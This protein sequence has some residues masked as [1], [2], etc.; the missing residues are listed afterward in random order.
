[1]GSAENVMQLLQEAMS[2][3]RTGSTK[4]NE[5]SSRSH[6][7]FRIVIESREMSEDGE[8][9][10]PRVEE[11]F[12]G[13]VRVAQLNLVDLAGSERAAHT[14][15]AGQRLKE[16]AHINKSLLTLGSVI[17]KLSEGVTA[18]NGHIPYRDSKL[19]R[20]LQTSLGGNAQTAMICTVT[21][22]SVHSDE[23]LSTL[24]FASRAKKIQN[25]AVVNEIYTDAALLKKLQK[26]INVLKQRNQELEA[27]VGVT[28]LESEKA[29]LEAELRRQKGEVGQK[30]QQLD[31][32]TTLI[33]KA[34]VAS[35][36]AAARGQTATDRRLTWAPGALKS[37]RKN[38]MSLAVGA[39][40]LFADITTDRDVARRGSLGFAGEARQGTL[41]RPAASPLLMRQ[42][43]RLAKGESGLAIPA[44]GLM[45]DAQ[46]ASLE[47]TVSEQQQQLEELQF[48]LEASNKNLEQSLEADIQLAEEKEHSAQLSAEVER[49]KEA[50]QQAE[51]QS[52]QLTARTEEVA[53][54]R[55]DATFMNEELAVYVLAALSLLH[56]F[57]KGTPFAYCAGSPCWLCMAF[58]HFNLPSCLALALSSLNG[59]TR[60]LHSAV[61]EAEGTSSP[62]DVE[63]ATGPLLDEI[64]ALKAKAAET[65][66][67]HKDLVSYLE[68]TVLKLQSKGR[69]GEL[70]KEKADL[71]QHLAEANDT[72]AAV[73]AEVNRLRE[74]ESA[75]A[76]E[77]SRLAA[78]VA[79]ARQEL[80]A[81]QEAL[82]VAKTAAEGACSEHQRLEE[83]ISS[84]LEGLIKADDALQA[85]NCK[86]QDQTD[87]AQSLQVQLEERDSTLATLKAELAAATEAT[88]AA[89]GVHMSVL[90]AETMQARVAE[91][92]K[93]LEM[94]GASHEGVVSS[95]RQTVMDLT[96]REAELS[97]Q[98]DTLKEELATKPHEEATDPST[99]SENA[100]S[101]EFA[102]PATPSRK[103]RGRIA[104]MVAKSPLAK[105]FRKKARRKL[106]QKS[107]ISSPFTEQ[108]ET[109]VSRVDKLVTPSKRQPDFSPEGE[110]HEACAERIAQ[111]Q[112]EYAELKQTLASVEQERN[113]SKESIKSTRLELQEGRLNLSSVESTL[114]ATSAAK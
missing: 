71:E 32:L 67:Q 81:E 20:I 6:S 26:E 87:R 34:G 54:L 1:M 76:A 73:T 79:A 85:A 2:N 100:T 49:L 24:K 68:E 18:A 31:R 97:A 51:L 46:I 17:S 47:K 59:T 61:A 86:A 92:E 83:E 39:D 105:P 91:L 110:G 99:S 23:T 48:M 8:E 82:A 78:E 111:L 28:Q 30:D 10:E 27:G 38:R 98:L 21:P 42:A 50:A 72:L 36:A 62:K 96:Q 35:P 109:C 13:A 52:V 107:D 29:T 65:E 12:D 43:S 74:S 5:E 56:E 101:E 3:R 9:R 106:G 11:E 80:S 89:E 84:M 102:M 108:D 103:S 75:S 22:A 4:M 64:S 88:K 40:G 16:G 69:A 113:E 94:E 33:L 57:L 53:K 60:S 77:A 114:I 104:T 15:A 41:K 7:I 95:L 70:E 66:A 58:L 93:Q 14:G 25:N 63:L 112:K 55:A 44:S 37:A 45:Q 19:T 90:V